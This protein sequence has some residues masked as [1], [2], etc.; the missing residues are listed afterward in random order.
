M[1]NVLGEPFNNGKYVDT[2]LVP[3]V[4]QINKTDL[5]VSF[6]L[7]NKKVIGHV[8]RFMT[9]KNHFFLIDIFAEYE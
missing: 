1:K 9:Q 3:E 2:G 5:L 7:E 4:M 6:N 8:G